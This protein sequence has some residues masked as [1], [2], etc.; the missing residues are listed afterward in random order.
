M[1]NT[2]FLAMGEW[3][4]NIAPSA[5]PALCGLQVYSP[6][7]RYHLFRSRWCG[8]DLRPYAKRDIYVKPSGGNQRVYYESGRPGNIEWLVLH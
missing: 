4:T 1:D 2:T 5:R 7:T 8:T 6:G 3:I